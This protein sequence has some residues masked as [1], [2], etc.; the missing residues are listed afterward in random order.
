MFEWDDARHF[1]ALHR[2]GSLSAAGR[3]LGVN[4]S[5]VGRRVAALETTLGVRLFEHSPN[6]YLL[7]DA[8]EQFLAHA[9]RIEDEAH[10]T[11]R[12]ISGRESMLTGTVRLTVSAGTFGGRFILPVL[13]ELHTK[14]PEIVLELVTDNRTLSLSKREADL[15]IRMSRPK[16]PSL[17]S[18]RLGTFAYGVYASRGYLAARGAPRPKDFAGHDVVAWLDDAYSAAECTWLEQHTHA[19]RVVFR[20][21]STLAMVQATT[22]GLGLA[23]LPCYVGD[24]EES[25]VRV[26]PPE[27]ALAR[28][29]WLVL[30]RDLRDAARVRAC[31]EFL[32]TAI[33]ARE[34]L[35]AGS[36]RPRGRA[37]RPASRTA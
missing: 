20:T 27:E 34:H 22:A 18:R 17:Y 15:A 9:E 16:E 31:V 8:G 23:L 29:L 11:M 21:N 25:L 30:H 7:T 35:L 10:A 3:Q 4:Q 36:D 6:G 19:G 12:Q 32:A 33:A 37:P 2:T 1:L 14:Y 24:S 13:V 28:E 5:T 26:L